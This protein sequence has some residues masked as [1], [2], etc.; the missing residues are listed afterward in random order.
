MRRVVRTLLAGTVVG[1]LTIGIAAPGAGA[2]TASASCTKASNIEA[3]VDDS[4]SMEFTDANRLRVQAMDLL[5]DSLS[6]STQLGAVEFGSAGF[7]NNP[8]A[9]DTVFPPEG[10]GANSAAMR[11][12]LDEKVHAD[13]GATDYNAAFAQADSDNPTADARIFLT[14]G[15]HDVGTYNEAHLVHNVRTY[16]IGFGGI[17]AG[18]DQERLKKIASDGGGRYFPLEDSAQLQAVMNTIETALTCQT[19]P[20]QFT[21]LLGKGQS[22]THSVAIGANTKSIQITL[23]WTSPL[24]KFKLSGLK[25]SNKGHLLAV[26]ARRGKVRKPGK[27]KVSRKVSST[28]TVLQVSHLHKGQLSFKVRAAKVGSGEP[29]VSL[30]TQVSQS[31]RK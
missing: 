23:T 24:D 14:D 5:I 30:T 21:D 20:R 26:A 10:I 1:L 3:I 13:N 28:F 17:A 18:E 11:A 31:A 29:K 22:K 27:L 9:A 19:P 25:L 8:P 15:G 2:A 12:A 6:S 4:I 16:V 7:E